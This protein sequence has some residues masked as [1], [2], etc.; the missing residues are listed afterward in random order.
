MSQILSILIAKFYIGTFLALPFYISN[1]ITLFPPCSC[2]NTDMS[3]SPRRDTIRIKLFL[4][5]YYCKRT[6]CQ[7]NSLCFLDDAVSI[8][9]LSLFL[10]LLLLLLLWWLSFHIYF[11]RAPFWG[12]AISEELWNINKKGRK[13]KLKC[14]ILL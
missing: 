11:C 12:I 14:E 1:T 10:P 8:D 6:S 9:F 7:C 4:H 13:V 5:F 2:T 3:L